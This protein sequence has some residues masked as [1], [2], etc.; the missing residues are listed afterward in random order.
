M[1]QA[2]GVVFAQQGDAEEHDVSGHGV[3]EDVA[4]VEVDEAV[5]Y[6]AGCGE[7]HGRGEGFGRIGMV[8]WIHMRC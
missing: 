2:L 3:C 6:T 5:E 8:C 1:A 7:K 4:V